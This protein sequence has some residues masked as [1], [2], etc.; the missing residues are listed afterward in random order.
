MFRLK[1]IEK[2]LKNTSKE[3]KNEDILNI[4]IDV[5]L[6]QIKEINPLVVNP[7]G[8][9]LFLSQKSLKNFEFGV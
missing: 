9:K 4:N 2:K 8:R 5:Y 3:L 1:R 7:K 6:R